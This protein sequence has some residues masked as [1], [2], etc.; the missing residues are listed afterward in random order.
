MNINNY[1]TLF[2]IIIILFP[3]FKGDCNPT[4]NHMLSLTVIQ[5]RVRGTVVLIQRLGVA[6][7]IRNLSIV[8]IEV[9]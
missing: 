2:Q 8:L 4:D 9:E 5:L 6:K 3:S 7:I 1:D